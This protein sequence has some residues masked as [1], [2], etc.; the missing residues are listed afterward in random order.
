M[1][2]MFYP[3]SS[4][5]CCNIF[6]ISLIA[7][8]DQTSSLEVL[9]LGLYSIYADDFR[10][11]IFNS[12]KHFCAFSHE[13]EEALVSSASQLKSIHHFRYQ[14]HLSAQHQR[15]KISP[16]PITG[17]L[18]PEA[19]PLNKDHPFNGIAYNVSTGFN[20]IKT[21]NTREDWKYRC[22]SRVSHKQLPRGQTRRLDQ[23]T[24]IVNQTRGLQQVTIVDKQTRVRG[25]D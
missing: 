4:S 23:E 8:E 18:F 22:M 3:I 2:P 21:D 20:S 11:N 13:E 12:R 14:S 6:F 9:A 19:R 25:L 1:Y 5:V 15:C 16:S 24:R 17:S 10:G 7:V